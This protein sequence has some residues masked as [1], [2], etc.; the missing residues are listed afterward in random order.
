MATL[1]VAIWF[2]VEMAAKADAI[3]SGQ[4]RTNVGYIVMF[5]A[6]TV[7]AILAIRGSWKLRQE[8]KSIAVQP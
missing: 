4:Q 2:A 1:I 3:M 8:R 6:L 7:M 5:S